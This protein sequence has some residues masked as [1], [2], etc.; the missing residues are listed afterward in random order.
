[1][2]KHLVDQK[3]VRIYINDSDMIDGV[4]LWQYI[5]KTVEESGM[6]GAT[7][8]KG[9]ASIGSHSQI[10]TFDIWT[11]SQELPV[12]IEVID[13]EEKI[14]SFIENCNKYIKEGLIVIQKVEAIIYS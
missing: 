4:P 7:V 3:L 13:T 11:L 6:A 5:L 10:H 9:V 8:F 1:M 14:R 12:V 2:K